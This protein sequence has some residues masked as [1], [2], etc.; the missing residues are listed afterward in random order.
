MDNNFGSPLKGLIKAIK[1]TGVLLM[2]SALVM[3]AARARVTLEPHQVNILGCHGNYS[4]AFAHDAMQALVNAMPHVC[5]ESLPLLEDFDPSSL[6]KNFTLIKFSSG[7]VSTLD[8]ATGKRQQNKFSTV[9][10][11]G[12]EYKIHVPDDG[13]TFVAYIRGHQ[14]DELCG[15]F[16]K[17]KCE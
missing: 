12:Q 13:K 17:L 11:D 14:E 7:T 5:N 1:R 6:L 2:K 9:G 3:S 4:E 10:S 8:F 15:K 16:M